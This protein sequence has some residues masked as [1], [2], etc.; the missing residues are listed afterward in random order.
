M[1]SRYSEFSR[2]AWTRHASSTGSKRSR[3]LRARSTS[4]GT[5]YEC[6]SPNRKT[7]RKYI[8]IKTELFRAHSRHGRSV[9]N[10][11]K[12]TLL[13]NGDSPVQY[14]IPYLRVW[15]DF[16]EC[17]NDDEI[18]LR[19]TNVPY[20]I[21]LRTPPVAT[22]VYLWVYIL[23]ILFFSPMKTTWRVPVYGRTVRL[24]PYLCVR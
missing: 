15:I 3:K 17:N 2:A 20:D 13:V 14:A 11:Y 6:A 16:V 19:K 22:I 7:N 24:A 5:N 21:V 10:V 4:F 23:Y 12:K 9:W 1:S 8:E 18:A